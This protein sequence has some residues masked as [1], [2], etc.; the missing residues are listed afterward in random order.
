MNRDRLGQQHYEE[1]EHWISIS[2]LMAGLMIVFLFV[3]VALMKA[4]IKERDRMREVAITYQEIQLAIYQELLD[5]FR[6]D[7]DQWGANID[8]ATLSVEFLSPEVLFERGKTT[9]RPKFKKILSDFFPRY[10]SV[11]KKFRPSIQEIRIEGHTSSIWNNSV[12]KDEAYFNNME[13]SQGR[14]RS[15]LQ[16]VYHLDNVSQDREWIRKTIA[17]VGYSFAHPKFTLDGKEDRDASRRVSFRIVT[18]AEAQI[19]RII[20]E[21]HEN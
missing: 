6:N 20:E 21:S 1:G 5:E 19:Q 4:A 16:Y 2:D 7:L 11:L 18:N 17:A 10:L 14:A 3:A 8:R 13:L 15:V 12:T 9:L